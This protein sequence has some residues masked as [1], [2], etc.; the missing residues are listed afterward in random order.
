VY[1][2][3]T[4]VAQPWARFRLVAISLKLL[5]TGTLAVRIEYQTQGSDF[6]S[7]EPPKV[8]LEIPSRITRIAMSAGR[9]VESIRR[10][11]QIRAKSS[12]LRS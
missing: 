5:P 7:T 6:R 8:D 4:W 11:K 12:T 9:L 3:R 10:P 1:N 2:C